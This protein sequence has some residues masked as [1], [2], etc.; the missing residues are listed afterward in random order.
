MISTTTETLHKM[1]GNKIFS[2][3]Y[4][5]QSGRLVKRL[6]QFGVKKYCKTPPKKYE[7]I[8]NYYDHSKQG[9]RFANLGDIKAIKQ[10]KINLKSNDFDQDQLEQHSYIV[11]TQ[12]IIT[13]EY[14]IRAKNEQEAKNIWQ[15]LPSLTAKKQTSSKEFINEVQEEIQK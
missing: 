9:Y 13:R 7:H 11:I 10:G 5:T 2:M 4:A 12:Q 1:L 3:V 15:K 8:I 6:C 14:R